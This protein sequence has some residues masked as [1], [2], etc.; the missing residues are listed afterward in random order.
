MNELTPCFPPHA[1]DNEPSLYH[2]TAQVNPRLKMPTYQRF[3]KGHPRFFTPEQKAI[4]LDR[5]GYT[6]PICGKGIGM[7]DSECHHMVSFGN[8]YGSSSIGNIIV[9]HAG[10][11][12]RM[13]DARSLANNDLIIGG[14]IFNADESMIR[15]IRSFE[16]K[17]G[18]L[19]NSTTQEH[20]DFFVGESQQPSLDPI[21][22]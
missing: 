8:A 20:T 19:H 1:R 16:K 9:V 15:D 4:A 12:H 11:C 7:H 6:C 10:E 2:P 14:N 17:F 18:K 5:Q 21:H 22:T 13:A 3:E